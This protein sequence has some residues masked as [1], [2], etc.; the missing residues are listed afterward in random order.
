MKAT[1]LVATLAVVLACACTAPPTTTPATATAEVP[2]A[3]AVIRTLPAGDDWRSVLPVT[4]GSSVA[5]VPFALKEVLLF[6]GESE[7]ADAGEGECYAAAE[8]RLRLRGIPAEDHVL[9]FLHDRLFRAEVVLRLSRDVPA[10]TFPRWCGEWV[11]GLSDVTRTAEHCAGRE[12]DTTFDAVLTYDTELAGPQLK[13]VVA[14]RRL[15]EP[16]GQP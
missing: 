13:V 1:R 12:G 8:P 6:R 15:P 9:C 2:A 3:P 14:D 16:A 11:T 10:D 4:L 7:G 5:Q